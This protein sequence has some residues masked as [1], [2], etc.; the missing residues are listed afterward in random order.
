VRDWNRLSRKLARIDL[1]RK[2]WEG[3]AVTPIALRRSARL[4]LSAITTLYIDLRYGKLG[5]KTGRNC[6]VD[7]H[8]KMLPR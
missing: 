1:T 6:R 3:P 2:D 4:A 7:C 8:L 5:G